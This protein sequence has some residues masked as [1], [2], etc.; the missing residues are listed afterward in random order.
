M[1]RVLPIDS[2]TNKTS[3]YGIMGGLAP[4]SGITASTRRHYKT[5]G[6][7]LYQNIPTSTPKAGLTYMCKNNLLSVNPQCSGGV[8]RLSSICKSSGWSV[9]RGNTTM[10]LR[11]CMGIV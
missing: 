1:S 2:I 6:A 9:N 7:K 10:S 5:A 11:D 3:T 8:G 4:T